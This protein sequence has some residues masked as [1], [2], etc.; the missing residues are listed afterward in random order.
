MEDIVV[1][2][3]GMI[4][5]LGVLPA[6]IV[7]AVFGGRFLKIK[8]RELAIRQQELETERERLVVL[9]LMEEHDKHDELSDKIKALEK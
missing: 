4:M 2:I 8:E 1:P 7:A 3:M 6:I 9:R 5:S